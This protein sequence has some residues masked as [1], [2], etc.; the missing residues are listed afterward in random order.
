MS[1][2]KIVLLVFIGYILV[3]QGFYLYEPT[4]THYE[5]DIK[6]EKITTDENYS[7]ANAVAINSLSKQKQ[8]VLFDAYKNS[9]NFLEESRTEVQMEEK[10]Q[11]SDKFQVINIEGVKLLVLFGG[12]ETYQEE[13]AQYM[14]SMILLQIGTS[15]LLITLFMSKWEFS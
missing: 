12:P 11:T 15:I 2:T 3:A 10:L 7:N 14:N 6:T 13:S 5:Y 8:T 9:D 4:E 1:K